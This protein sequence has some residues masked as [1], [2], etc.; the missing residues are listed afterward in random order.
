[1]ICITALIFGQLSS[2]M[3]QTKPIVI[4]GDASDWGW[5]LR[6]FK[7]EANVQYEF[8]NDNQNLYVILK[9]NVAEILI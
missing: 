9:S 1:M 2:S 6:F 4:D 8:R 7:P 5:I 3:W